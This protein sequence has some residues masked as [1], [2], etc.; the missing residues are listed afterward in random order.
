MRLRWWL[1]GGAVVAAAGVVLLASQDESG[2]VHIDPA[3]GKPVVP[4]YE[5]VIV[6][7]RPPGQVSRYEQV[8]V[9]PAP[10]PGREP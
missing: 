7:E 8:I 10:A 4:R 5:R 6:T 2:P 3:T 9:G 1:L